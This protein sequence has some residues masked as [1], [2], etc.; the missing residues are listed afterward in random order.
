[1]K[2]RKMSGMKRYMI[3]ICLVCVI[4]YCAY[5]IYSITQQYREEAKTH[6]ALLMYKPQ[7]PPIQ[8]KPQTPAPGAD[9][10][11]TQEAAPA[12]R[13][14]SEAVQA[15]HTEQAHPVNQSIISLKARNED[16]VGWVSI[17]DTNVDYPFVQTEDNRYYLH[18]DF[19]KKEAAA[20]TLFLDFR[21]HP[22]L[23]HFNNYIYGHS[24]KNG[25]MFGSLRQFE[26]KDY[27]DAH[28]DATVT[29]L[30]DTYSAEV[31]AYMVVTSDNE[32]IYQTHDMLPRLRQEY[33]DYVKQYARNYREIDLDVGDSIL[34][35]STCAY[36]FN[37]ARVVLLMRLNP[38][39][40]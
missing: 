12:Q 8:T 29:L 9:A 35:L 18:R 14:A 24:M 28:P 36:E 1:M 7:R 40:P 6:E 30:A 11:Q 4:G 13:I 15:S 38:I 17:H 10:T 33:F 34:T 32:M 3:S 27:F 5:S 26:K 20:G 2:R 37:D 23:L 16:A 22:R 21:N 31:F 39:I 25:S 19:D